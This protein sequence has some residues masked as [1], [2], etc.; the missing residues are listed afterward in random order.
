MTARKAHFTAFLDVVGYHESAWRARSGA[1]AE[2]VSPIDL[3]TKT[4]QS[5]ERGKIDSVFFQDTPGLALFRAQYFPQYFYD[6][7]ELLPAFAVKTEHIGLIASAS[8]TYNDP[9]NL[10]RRFATADHI[11]AGR[12]G[13][14][15]VTTR[16]AGAAKNF[17]YV[18]HPEHDFRYLRAEE[19]VDAA[20]RLWEGWD[21]DAVV[22]NPATGAWADIS[23]IHEANFFGNF[24]NVA[25][26]LP[27]PRSPQGRPAFAQ[28][29]SS[30][31]GIDLGGRVADVIFAAKP[32]KAAASEFK[33]KIHAS[34]V[35]H[36]RTPDDVVVLPGLS[37][38]L[39]P[40][41]SEAR[42]IRQNLESLVNGE[43]RWRL[44]ALNSGLNPDLIDP[45][46]PLSQEA[47]AA[48]ERTSRTDD[49]IEFSKRTDKSFKQVAAYMTGLPGGLQFTGTPEQMADLIQ[50]WV[51]SGASDGFTLQPEILPD[52]IELFVD[53]V[54]PILQRRGLYR[55]DYSATTLRGHLRDDLPLAETDA[56]AAA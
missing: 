33:D 16:Y 19:F 52:S 5:A 22:A 24:F 30:V 26:A 14:N 23:K 38:V 9:Y 31:P 35:R 46:K 12:A 4:V 15:I 51:T 37:Y 40:T 25:G 11:S 13:W 49:V 39:A 21:E 54:V 27:L 42:S 8:T 53:H 45:D 44:L 50:D 7:V 47:I 36:G 2:S 55:T 43:F 1:A 6:A 28:A 10:A 32:N 41:E 29:G 17:G 3:L 18:H 34:A 48:A 56:D 20:I